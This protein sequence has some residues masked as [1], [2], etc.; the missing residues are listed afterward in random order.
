MLQL[1]VTSIIVWLLV[2]LKRP[3]KLDDRIQIPTVGLKG[4]IL[5]VGLMFTVLNQVRPRE[6]IVIF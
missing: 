1:V 3:F 4:V 2:T 6:T 5:K